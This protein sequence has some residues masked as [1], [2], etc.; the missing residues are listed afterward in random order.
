ML[1]YHNSEAEIMS[2]SVSCWSFQR[3]L[4]NLFRSTLLGVNYLPV[5]SFYQLPSDS[6][7]ESVPSFLEILS[8]LH[9]S[10]V[11]RLVQITVF[12]I[13]ELW[14]CKQSIELKH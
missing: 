2:P 4:S 9:A 11:F 14:F 6:F 7:F 5:R 12:L 8:T 1:F 13:L 10:Y 3:F